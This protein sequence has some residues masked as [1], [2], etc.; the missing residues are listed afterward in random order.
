MTA[1][2]LQRTARW[3][4]NMEGGIDVR[5]LFC[6]IGFA[7]NQPQKLRRVILQ[8]ELGICDQLDAF[9]DNLIDTYQDEW[10]Q[11]VKGNWSQ[12]LRHVSCAQQCI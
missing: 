3:I 9:M 4:E 8:D 12:L 6:C 1:D 7:D 5:S 11:V 2:R 10:A